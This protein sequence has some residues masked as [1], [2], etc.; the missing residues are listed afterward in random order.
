MT[1]AEDAYWDYYDNYEAYHDLYNES[2]YGSNWTPS[3]YKPSGPGICPKCG[4]NTILRTNKTTKQ[5]FYGCVKFP[6]CK[7]NRNE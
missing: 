5:K 3:Y 1:W 7:G 6:K 4:S 2:Y